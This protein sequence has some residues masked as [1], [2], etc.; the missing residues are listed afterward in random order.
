M[1]GGVVASQHIAEAPASSPRVRLRRLL[2]VRPAVLVGTL[3]LLNLADL[4]T[5][6][7]VLDRGGDEGNPV[8]RPFVEGVWGAALLKCACVVTIAAL[9]SRCAGSLRVRV[10][11]CLVVAWYA[12]VVTWNATVLLRS[13]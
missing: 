3:A 9:V 8:M 6:R 7:L 4:V 12:A 10:G 5:T 13:A 11:L 2:D 1:P